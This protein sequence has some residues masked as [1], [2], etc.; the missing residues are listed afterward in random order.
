MDNHQFYQFAETARRLHH[1]M[2]Q[3][4]PSAVPSILAADAVCHALAIEKAIER[5]RPD[6]APV[7]TI[8]HDQDTP[9][10]I[11]RLDPSDPDTW[12]DDD[13][14]CRIAI[15]DPLSESED[16]PVWSIMF[17]RWSEPTKTWYGITTA[18]V[19]ALM[20]RLVYW[21]DGHILT[22]QEFRAAM[23]DVEP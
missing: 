8:K 15:Y 3:S 14:R 6:P 17:G 1:A 20:F 5:H 11:T 4:D 13:Q 10:P 21:C 18:L 9:L 16:V 22:E 12:P 7:K 19:S 23:K 2:V